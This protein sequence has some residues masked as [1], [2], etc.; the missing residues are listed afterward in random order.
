ME[1]SATLKLDRSK[2]ELKLGPAL[3]IVPFEIGPSPGPGPLG[4]ASVRRNF[5]LHEPST[6][7]INRSCTRRKQSFPSRFDV[8]IENCNL[9]SLPM[10][11][12]ASIKRRAFERRVD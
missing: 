5:T 1:S 3:K 10:Y 2:I 4:R 7:V 6:S 9:Q 12:L 11:L 8:K